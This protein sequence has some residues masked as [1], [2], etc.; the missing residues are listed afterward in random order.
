VSDT[1]GELRPELFEVFKG[2]DM[3]VHAGDIGKHCILEELRAIA[4]VVAVRG[5]MDKGSWAYEL[6]KNEVVE[7]GEV[8]LYVLHDAARLNIEPSV[9]GTS[10]VISGHSHS[11]GI[12][13]HNGVLYLNPGSAGPKRFRL[14][15]SVA[16]L[17]IVGKSAKA[18][19]LKLQ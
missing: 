14:P 2:V 19:I 11:P 15:V 5:N 9:S 16:L 12:E 1:H 7:I 17:D 6:R 4:P 8:F 13:E 18:Q 10:V 3:I